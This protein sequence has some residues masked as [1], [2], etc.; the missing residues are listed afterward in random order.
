MPG[1]AI[2]GSGTAL[3][4]CVPCL[5]PSKAAEAL[6]EPTFDNALAGKYPLGRA[7]YIYVNK[8]PNEPLPPLVKEFVKYVLS[9]EGQEVVIKDGYGPLPI[10]VIEKQLKLI[11]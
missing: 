5:W 6:V 9:K 8:K 2:P 1:S 11:E 7:L 10:S 3:P 4:K